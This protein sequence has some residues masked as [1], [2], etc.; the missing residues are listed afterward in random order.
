MYTTPSLRPRRSACA[1]SNIIVLHCSFVILFMFMFPN[2][3]FIILFETYSD[4]MLPEPTEAFGLR[5]ELRIFFAL[6]AYCC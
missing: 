3:F 2:V 6:C 4:T 1:C 5:C